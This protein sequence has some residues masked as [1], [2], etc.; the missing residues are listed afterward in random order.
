MSQPVSPDSVENRAM[1]GYTLAVSGRR[2][3]ANSVLA[4]LLEITRRRSVDPFYPAI[5]E[6]ALGDNEAAFGWLEKAYQERSE[7]LLMLKTDPRLDALRS[8]P[9]FANLVHRIGLPK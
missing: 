8:D 5:I 2:Q 4:D 3:L 1:I 9:R 7:E 6:A